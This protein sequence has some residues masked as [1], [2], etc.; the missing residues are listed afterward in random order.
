MFEII[1]VYLVCEIIFYFVSKWTILQEDII[2]HLLAGFIFTIPV[3]VSCKLRDV[4]Y[5]NSKYFYRGVCFTACLLMLLSGYYY[6]DNYQAPEELANFYTLAI[7]NSEVCFF[8]VFSYFVKD[9]SGR[10]KI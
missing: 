4:Y 3:S 9:P 10:V 7:F 1:T 6:R 2:L 5:S 8:I